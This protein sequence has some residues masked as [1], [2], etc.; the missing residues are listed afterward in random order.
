M[1]PVAHFLHEIKAAL[2]VARA[3]SGSFRSVALPGRPMR[4]HTASVR[5]STGPGGAYERGEPV[6]SAAADR[7]ACRSWRRQV[8]TPID[9]TLCWNDVRPPLEPAGNGKPHRDARIGMEKAMTA[10][11]R[12]AIGCVLTL[13][14]MTGASGVFA[15][16]ATP[17]AGPSILQAYGDAW[18]SGDAAEVGAL[19][20]ENAVRDDV[21]TGTVSE[22]RAAIEKLADALFA[23]DDNVRLEVTD[24]FVGENWVVVE[25]TF[26][27]AHPATGR[28]VTFRGASVLE[29]TDGLIS[30]ERD[31][32]DLPEM[33]AQI[34]AASATP[35]P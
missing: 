18:S 6:N 7:T 3:S 11:I 21:P 31:Y 30:E 4:N 16:D 2:D 33:M 19:Y 26:S 12:A 23:S 8:L 28:E 27:G 15:Q 13:I 35:A 10:R 25:W 20:T 34:E 32:Y 1:S 9:A 29:L 22:G 17:A 14:L 24:G 5:T